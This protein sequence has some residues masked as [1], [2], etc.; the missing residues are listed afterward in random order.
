MLSDSPGNRA[1]LSAE[2]KVVNI[3]QELKSSEYVSLTAQSVF[4]VQDSQYWLAKQ[5]RK[6]ASKTLESIIE[7][8][9]I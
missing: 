7:M 3:I 9:Q 2:K 6:Q 5:E 4:N 1:R 8:T